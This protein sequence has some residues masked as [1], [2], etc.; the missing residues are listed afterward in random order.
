MREKRER[1]QGQGVTRVRWWSWQG[2][3]VRVS[4]GW[5]LREQDG[6]KSGLNKRGLIEQGRSGMLRTEIRMCRNDRRRISNRK[7][8][9]LH[10]RQIERVPEKIRGAK[11]RE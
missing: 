1:Q 9:R 6:S 8:G 4:D 11:K 2:E 7:A 3:W 5:Q 10:M